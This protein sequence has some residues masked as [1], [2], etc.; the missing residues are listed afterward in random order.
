LPQTR[1]L[2]P[3]RGRLPGEV[4]LTAFGIPGY[5][6]RRVR[7]LKRADGSVQRD[8]R[9]DLYPPTP[10][11]LETPP[12]WGEEDLSETKITI[13]PAAVRPV[14]VQLRPSTRVEWESGSGLK[15]SDEP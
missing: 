1:V 4:R 15:A 7:E 8:V 9:T 12:S 6:V 11:I 2:K 13:D 10:E 14:L 3:V 5:R